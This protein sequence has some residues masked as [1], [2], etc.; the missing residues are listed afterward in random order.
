MSSQGRGDS[1]Q[2]KMD[3][4]NFIIVKLEKGKKT[5]EMLADPDAA[6]KAKQYIGLENQKREKQASTPEQKAKAM[7]TVQ[8]VLKDPQITISDIFQSTEVFENIKKAIRVPEAEIKEIFG[9]DNMDV[10]LAT[11]LLEGEFNWTKKQRDE[12][13]ETKK[14]KIIQIITMNSINPQTKKPHPQARIEKAMEEAKVT[15][16]MVK[17]PEDQVDDVL[18]KLQSV[19]PIKMEKAEFLLKIPAQYAA[20]AYNIVDRYCTVLK[21]EW[22]NDGSWMGLVSMPAGLQTEFFDKINKLTQGRA[23]IEK[24][25]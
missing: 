21:S 1:S 22:Q 13:Q 16:D 20:K 15:I 8:E 3:L 7:M 19:I 9:T 5:F 12:I 11:F 4:S 24:S 25:K 2:K 14:K 18:K 10:I 6:W 17:L 23:I